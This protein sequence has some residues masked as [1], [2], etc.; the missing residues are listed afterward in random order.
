MDQIKANLPTTSADQFDFLVNDLY[1]AAIH[2]EAGYWRA[3]YEAGRLYL[4]KHNQADAA[5]E[6][7][8][9]LAGAG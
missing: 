2:S 8:A 5:R 4:E 6:F 1:P 7:K 3:H 9:A